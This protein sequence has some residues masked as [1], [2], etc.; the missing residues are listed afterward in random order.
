MKSTGIVRKVDELGRIVLPIEL[1]RTLHIEIGDA[2]EVYVDPERI[3]LKKYT[4]ACVFCGN[5]EN[6][7]YFKGKLVCGT[8]MNEIA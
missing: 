4:P 6:M 8:C 2:I 7:S 5:F 1:R 3:T